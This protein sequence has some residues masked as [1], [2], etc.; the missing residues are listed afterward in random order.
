MVEQFELLVIRISVKISPGL[1]AQAGFRRRKRMRPYSE[2]PS[3]KAPEL[4]NLDL[5]FSCPRV[6]L[7]SWWQVWDGPRV[8][9]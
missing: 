5:R 6:H 8:Q 4:H 9:P 3:S 7:R 2:R 1:L